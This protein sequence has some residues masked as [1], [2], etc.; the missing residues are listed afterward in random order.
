MKKWTF[1]FKKSGCSAEEWR[2][3]ASLDT[4]G[5]EWRGTPASTRSADF[6]IR[7]TA[8]VPL[9]SPR[10]RR[11]KGSLAANIFNKSL[12]PRHSKGSL[13][14]NVPHFRTFSSSFHAYA[15][16]RV[17]YRR[18]FISKS[19]ILRRAK[20]TFPCLSAPDADVILRAILVLFPSRTNALWASLPTSTAPAAIRNVREGRAAVLARQTSKT[21]RVG[22][23]VRACVR[24]GV[25]E[26]GRG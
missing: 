2:G 14:G 23:C 5:R 15:T 1:V 22:A 16:L 9:K 17:V 26:K 6:R 19:P 11:C 3:P 25:R 8:N 21:S 12:R 4:D 18:T 24:V 20:G 10:P 13:S 7:R